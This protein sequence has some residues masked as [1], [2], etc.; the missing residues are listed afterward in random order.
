MTLH[1]FFICIPGCIFGKI[2]SMCSDEFG[3]SEQV[4]NWNKS[5]RYLCCTCG[6]VAAIDQS[7]HS[8]HLNKSLFNVAGSI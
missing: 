8:Y 4:G 2:W 5:K 1:V 3:L 6:L 7:L